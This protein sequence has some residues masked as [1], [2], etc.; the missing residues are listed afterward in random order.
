MLRVAGNYQ[1]PEE[2][3]IAPW[4]LQREHS[5]TDTLILDF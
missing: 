2:G 1:K 3:Q 4:S 5:Y